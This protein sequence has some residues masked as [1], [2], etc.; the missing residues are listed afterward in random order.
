M[1][2]IILIL[3]AITAITE[4][5]KKYEEG[6]CF[7][8]RS[9]LKRIYGT[10]QLKEYT[11]NG[12]DSLGLFKDSLCDILIFF[13]DKNSNTNGCTIENIRDD[14]ISPSLVWTWELIEKNKILSVTY[15][16]CRAGIGTVSWPS[17]TGPFFDKSKPKWE[18][19]RLTNSEIKMK[20]TYNNKEYL[21]EL[22]GS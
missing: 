13:Y 15:S 11:V 21:I 12:I 1:K 4:G 7:S 5:C 9:P 10:Y 17:G 3:I 19:I 8:L 20:T 14:G 18:I 6:S 16:S 2:K 22:K